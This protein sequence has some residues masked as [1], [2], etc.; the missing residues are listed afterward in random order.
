MSSGFSVDSIIPPNRARIEREILLINPML[1]LILY[2]RCA[3][4]SVALKFPRPYMY[5]EWLRRVQNT[6]AKV[7][8]SIT[9]VVRSLPEGAPD[10]RFETKPHHQL[11]AFEFSLN[12]P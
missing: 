7:R 4:F 8:R 3:I 2:Q 5:D 12:C 11:A 6:T 9:G 10:S 1:S